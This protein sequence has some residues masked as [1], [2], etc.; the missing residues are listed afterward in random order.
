MAES[1][2]RRSGWTWRNTALVTALVAAPVLLIPAVLPR[3]HEPDRLTAV[4]GII[5]FAL[6]LG[7]AIV[8][9]VHWRLTHSHG[10]GWLTTCTALLAVHGMTMTAL[11]LDGAPTQSPVMILPSLVVAVVVAAMIGLAEVVT[12]RVDALALGLWLGLLAALGDVGVAASDPGAEEAPLS[13]AAA[14]TL[15]F[16]GIVIVALHRLRTLPPW[17]RQRLQIAVAALA[18]SWVVHL[19]MQTDAGELSA[20]SGPLLLALGA[21]ATGIALL[22]AVAVGLLRAAL[23]ENARTI[24][25]LQSRLV[26]LELSCR[27]DRETIH[28]LRG[29]IAGIVSA[30]ELLGAE[31]EVNAGGL[32]PAFGGTSG[33]GVNALTE[34]LRSEAARLQRLL[35]AEVSATPTTVGLDDVVRPL[36]VA[37][38]VRGLDVSFEPSGLQVIAVADRLSEVVNILLVNAHTHA[39]G[40]QVCIDAERHAD[41][42]VVRVVDD[43]P[44]IPPE[45]VPTLFER[46]THGPESPGSGIGLHVARRLMAQDGNFLDLDGSHTGGTAF[47]LGLRAA[48]RRRR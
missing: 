24:A 5:L 27:A 16:G 48:D 9:E 20:L 3:I 38:R 14:A 26:E 37:H 15:V 19:S 43:G 4:S 12:P 32:R 17:A 6:M 1:A 36:V 34:M 28:E 10:T 33:S 11:D 25:A 46:G 30:A 44:G 47:I 39:R 41:R 21:M 45:L 42:V 22:C 31:Q 35:A 29:S 18:T 23:R 8:L 7:C 2:R 13:W 40:A